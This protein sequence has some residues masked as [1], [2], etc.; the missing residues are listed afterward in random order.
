M[1]LAELLLLK[2]YSMNSP[3]STTLRRKCCSSKAVPCP[4]PSLQELEVISY[5]FVC[6]YCLCVRTN[7]YTVQA[8][9]KI[10]T[11]SSCAVTQSKKWSKSIF[12]GLSYYG[13]NLRI[14]Q[15][16]LKMVI[17]DEMSFDKV[18][19]TE[20][21]LGYYNMQGNTVLEFN[22]FCRWL[23]LATLYK[24]VVAKLT[25]PVANIAGHVIAHLP[26]LVRFMTKHIS[27]RSKALIMPLTI[28]HCVLSY[29]QKNDFSENGH[30]FPRNYLHNR[31]PR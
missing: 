5:I 11:S 1:K 3:G 20:F 30:V 28:W 10:I 4:Y 17:V 12:R 16:E 22:L 8:Q 19:R 2:V 9:T 27:V 18:L 23:V 26:S 29:Q 6:L 24:K 31:I 14:M 15:T 13:I 25:F 21:T 7:T